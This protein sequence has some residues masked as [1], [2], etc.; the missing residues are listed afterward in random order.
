MQR[1]TCEATN[2]QSACQQDT[3]DLLT[4]QISVFSKRESR[5]RPRGNSALTPKSSGENVVGEEFAPRR[6]IVYVKILRRW[7]GSLSD[8]RLRNYRARIRARD[9]PAATLLCRISARHNQTSCGS[10]HTGLCRSGERDRLRR[11]TCTLSIPEL[12]G[13]YRQEVERGRMRIH[14]PAAHP[15]SHG[16][17]ASLPRSRGAFKQ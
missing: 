7:P 9:P 14:W 1:L 13:G 2:P 17:L 15:H 3:A 10:P 16:H 8:G 4:V 6:S 5:C 12:Q 11:W